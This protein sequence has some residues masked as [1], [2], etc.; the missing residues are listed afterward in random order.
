MEDGGLLTTL[1]VEYLFRP[2]TRWKILALSSDRTGGKN[3]SPRH[4]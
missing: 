2:G 1:S 3:S 4:R